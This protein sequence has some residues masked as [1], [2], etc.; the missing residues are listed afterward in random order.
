M[1]TSCIPRDLSS[2][3]NRL[4]TTPSVRQTTCTMSSDWSPFTKLVR[5]NVLLASSTCIKYQLT[6]MT[7]V[8]TTAIYTVFHKI[9]TPLY[10]CNNF[11]KC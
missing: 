11:F 4:D 8:M 7:V 10:F 5:V 1:R 6:M 9:G 2:Q 3:T